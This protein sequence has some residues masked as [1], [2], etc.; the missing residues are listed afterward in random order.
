[1]EGEMR[2]VDILTKIGLAL[3]LIVWF[4][5]G[6][7]AHDPR[8]HQVTSLGSAKSKAGTLCCDG[9]D[10]TIPSNWERTPDG[11]R[12]LIRDTW[13]TVPK[14]AVVSNVP[15]PD[16]EAKVWLLTAEGV[17]LVRC[18]MPGAEI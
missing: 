18:F 13:L 11:F 17:M 6:A 3:I 1:M 2:I 15:N 7:Q 9:K 5:T 14:D 16:I 12:V 8:T 10:Y 4:H